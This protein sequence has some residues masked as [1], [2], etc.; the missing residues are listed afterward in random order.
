MIGVLVL[1]LLFAIAI[2]VSLSPSPQVYT[3]V[4][5][6]ID[7]SKPQSCC[8]SFS[9]SS[10]TTISNSSTDGKISFS[11]ISSMGRFCVS[12]CDIISNFYISIYFPIVN[13]L[14]C[15]LYPKVH[16]NSGDTGSN[17]N[18]KTHYSSHLHHPNNH[19]KN[20]GYGE[21]PEANTRGS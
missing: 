11:S 19:Q 20:C 15:I 18:P 12:S 7:I 6:L 1:V 8:K 4:S 14:L 9:R 10:R 3:P 21:M 13:R 2:P 16:G 17:S 5:L